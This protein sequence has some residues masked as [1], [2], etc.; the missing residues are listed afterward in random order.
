VLVRQ[1]GRPGVEICTTAASL[2]TVTET[3][4][5]VATFDQ[6]DPRTLYSIL[7]LR[8]DVFI[9]EQECAYQDL[10]GRDD[11]AGTR[12]IW[13]TTGAEPLAYLRVL[14][15][16]DGTAIVGR[17]VVAATA[18]RRGYAQQLLA[19]AIELIGDQESALNAQTYAKDLYEAA[20]YWI[21][22]PEFIED[23]IPHLPMKRLPRK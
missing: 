8:S 4:L 15:E 5:H 3:Q 16:P 9:V 7:K 1:P 11:E 21:Y 23:G 18:R 17:V 14:Q 6:L 10:D 2:A 22:G 13:L 19:A 12:H 20:G